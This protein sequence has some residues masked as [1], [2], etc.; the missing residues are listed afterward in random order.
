MNESFQIKCFEMAQHSLAY[1]QAEE[2]FESGGQAPF[3][4][5]GYYSDIANEPLHLYFNN[6]LV[7]VATLLF[8]GDGAELHK[9]YIHPNDRGQGIGQVADL[10]SIDYMFDKYGVEEV[11]VSMLGN[12]AEFWRKIVQIYGERAIHAGPNCFFVKV[13]ESAKD[14]YPYL[15]DS[16]E[17]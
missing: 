12:S 4:E 7:G 6:H 14:C 3:M 17:L 13:G 8:V 16:N 10:A 1:S 15:F 9:L 2:L 11:Y 5:V